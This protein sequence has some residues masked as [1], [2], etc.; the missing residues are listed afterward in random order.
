V[1][2]DFDSMWL[3]VT[4]RRAF[5]R[6]QISGNEADKTISRPRE[7]DKIME[8]LPKILTHSDFA[9]HITPD[10]TPPLVLL[11]P[12]VEIMRAYFPPT[13]SDEARAGATAKWQQFVDK[14]LNTCT[15]VRGISSGWGLE[16]DF[17][18]HG[19]KEGQKAA[20]FVALIGWDSVDDHMRFR[21]TKE[22]KDHVGL[23][24][25]M[26]ELIKIEMVHVELRGVK[27]EESKRGK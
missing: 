13:V 23:L 8:A 26:D 24:G 25:D 4:I 27:R 20:A 12:V 15:D 9:K 1:E 5:P 14:A 18:M 10:P 22:Y 11:S 21:E 17:P 16:K 3:D 7:G 19:D 2:V 6:I